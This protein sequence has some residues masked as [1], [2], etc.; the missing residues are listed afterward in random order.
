MS[1]RLSAGGPE[2]PQLMWVLWATFQ[3]WLGIRLRVGGEEK[4]EASFSASTEEVTLMAGLSLS[5][6]F[7][8]LDECKPA[9][10]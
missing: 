4:R 6:T 10:R 7:M 3:V 1:V 9:M 2:V 8:G 5:M